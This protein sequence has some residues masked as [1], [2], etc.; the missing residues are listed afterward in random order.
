MWRG[1][2]G[3]EGALEWWWRGRE[4]EGSD[5][6]SNRGQYAPLEVLAGHLGVGGV[7]GVQVGPRGLLV[8][9]R[10]PLVEDLEGWGRD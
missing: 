1:W 3:G 10:Q 6:G 4:T 7:L 8:V 2:G 9:L 5:V